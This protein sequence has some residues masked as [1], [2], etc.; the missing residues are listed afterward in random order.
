ML[1]LKSQM[2][3]LPAYFITFQFTSIKEEDIRALQT[4]LEDI[5]ARIRP[6]AV[7]V[8]D[9]FDIPDGVLNSALGVYDGNVYERLFEEAMKSPLNHEPVPESFH[10]YLKPFMKS[11][12]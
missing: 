9:G 7:G 6:N 2:I 8:V 1:K 5:L 10:K 12:L 11:N 4:R 3:P